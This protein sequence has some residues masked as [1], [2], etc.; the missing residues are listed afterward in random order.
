MM[1]PRT[2]AIEILLTLA[3]AAWGLGA[4]ITIATLW[5][6]EPHAG[7]LPGAMLA[8][9]LDARGPLR[10]I[11][12]VILS[13]LIAAFLIRPLAARASTAQPWVVRAMTVALASGLWLAL[14]DPFESI[15]ILFVPPMA[16]GALFLARGIEGRFTRRDI[17]LIPSTITLYMTLAAIAPAMISPCTKRLCTRASTR[18]ARY[19][20]R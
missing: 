13:P 7:Q 3:G 1:R 17:I 11:V 9:G 5:V 10:A 16:A 15:V 19:C 2:P 20:D 12:S 14:V 8:H 4:G 6:A 18:P